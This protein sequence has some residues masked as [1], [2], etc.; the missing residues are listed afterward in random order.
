MTNTEQ[1]TL[2]EKELTTLIKKWQDISQVR[3]AFIIEDLQAIINKLRN[4]PVETTPLEDVQTLYIQR[5]GTIPARYKNDIKRL[6]SK[7]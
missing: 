7:L 2:A 3:V 1:Q 6:S 4:Q 5:H